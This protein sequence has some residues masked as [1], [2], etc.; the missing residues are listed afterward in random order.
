MNSKKILHVDENHPCLIAGL[1][2]LGFKN[3]TAYHTPL[4]ELLKKIDQYT[5]LIIRSR[6]PIDQQFIDAASQL[7]FIGRVGAGLENIDLDYAHSKNIHLIAAPE[8]NRNAVGEHALGMLLTLTNKLRLG[9]QA[10][11]HGKWLREAHRGWELEG[12]T[13][14]IIGYG[15][16]GNSFAQK[17]SGFDVTVLC[18]DIKTDVGNNYAKQV[19]LKT[20]Q[21]QSDVISL[22]IPQTP[23]A[24]RLIDHR[25]IAAMKKPFWFLNTA[26]GSAVVTSDLV[27]GLK[28]GKVFG[29]GLDVLEYESKSF[30]SIFNSQNP[31]EPLKY[32]LQSENVLLSPHVGGWTVESHKKLAETIV[33]KVKKLPF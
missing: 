25:F 6:F 22:H 14:G 10:I 33:E 8:G 28:S 16:T 12:K 29:A 17:L 30:T 26:R 20:L 4:E 15:N 13:I 2:A 24:H 7:A 19:S 31:P 3:D 11:Q 5:G 1:E 27:N 32:L 21:E 18:H 9:H 23:L